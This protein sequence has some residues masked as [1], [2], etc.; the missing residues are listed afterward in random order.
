M[1]SDGELE[2]PPS[3]LKHR[4]NILSP[5][6]PNIIAC[7]WGKNTSEER[8]TGEA[9]TTAA[10]CPARE[11]PPERRV[12]TPSSPPPRKLTKFQSW[13]ATREGCGS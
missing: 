9:T 4:V 2:G 11:I 13:R 3:L 1:D 7:F 5:S 12:I 8:N 10:H 6:L